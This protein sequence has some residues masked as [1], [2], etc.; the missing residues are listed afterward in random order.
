MGSAV[1]SPVSHK[2]STSSN[3]T[4]LFFVKSAPGGPKNS[5]Q[6][7]EEHFPETDFSIYE[8][9][10][11][12]HLLSS[13]IAVLRRYDKKS[14]NS[15]IMHKCKMFVNILHTMKASDQFGVG[16]LS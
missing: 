5:V 13:P 2:L 4:S 10:F 7:E 15:A 6:G 14:S 16:W 1:Y 9:E 12:M 8:R 3:V 11:E